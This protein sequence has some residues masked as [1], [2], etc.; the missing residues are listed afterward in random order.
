MKRQAA[1]SISLSI[2][3]ILISPNSFAGNLKKAGPLVASTTVINTLLT[4][5]VPPTSS[6]GKNGDVYIDVKNA[7]LYGPKKKGIWPLGVSLKGTDGKNGNDGKAGAAG[8]VSSTSTPGP[9]GPQ[10]PKGDIGPQGPPGLQGPKGDVPDIKQ[11]ADKFNQL[12]VD[13]TKRFDRFTSVGAFAG[14]GGSGSYWLYDLGDT[15]PNLKNATDGQ[16]LTYS[17]TTKKWAAQDPTGGGGGA[18]VDQV[19]RTTANA[20]FLT[21]NAAFDYANTINL[22]PYATQAYVTTQIANLVNSAPTTLDTLKELADALGDDPNFATTIT[23]S[24]GTVS[25]HSNAAFDKAN[26][27]NVLAQNAYNFANTVNVK[28][29]S[30]YAFANTVN[31]KVDSAY[32]FAN[33]V[34]I[35]TDSAYAFANTVNVKVDS[36]YAFANTVNVKV[37]SAYAFANTVN[38]SAQAA[39][40]K[41][42]A[43]LSS[44]GFLANSVIFANSTGYISNTS[45]IQFFTSNNSFQVNGDIFT[46]NGNLRTTSTTANVFNSTPTTIN[47]GGNTTTLNIGGSSGIVTISGTITS[48]VTV[49]SNSSIASSVGYLGMPQNS[50]ST[51]Y[52]L[53]IGDQGKHI[54][55]TAN[56]TIT[57]PSNANVPFP[58]G[59]A[60][61]IITNSGVTANV[62]ISTDN[63]ILGGIGTTG[64]RTVSPYGMATIIKVTATTWFISGAGVA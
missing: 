32:A 20:A 34:N 3:L 17:T 12:T 33:T 4:G 26:S 30:A 29:D 18:G 50:Q 52:T 49:A 58:I 62:A 37:D 39:F 60:V 64:T 35:K 5:S 6:V 13:I 47:F 54:Y 2:A 25:T 31:V 27:A 57:I 9:A 59:A 56:G 22:T 41:A 14:G 53:V 46:L 48:N 61:T 40:N 63:L 19:A 16:V 10:G 42:N 24:I 11:F 51:N 21:A 45:N 7:M 8:A 43:A 1:I 15:D 44:S 28:T 23:A 55:L 38:V 36:A